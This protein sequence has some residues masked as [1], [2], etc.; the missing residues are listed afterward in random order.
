MPLPLSKNTYFSSDLHFGHDNIIK[1]CNRPFANST[2]MDDFLFKQFADLPN[3]AQLI[4]NGD[5][6]LRGSSFAKNC[7]DKIG[8]MWKHLSVL[9]VRG[10]HDVHIKTSFHHVGVVPYETVVTGANDVVG[11]N[12]HPIEHALDCNVAFCGHVHDKWTTHLT[13]HGFYNINVGWDIW[14]KPVTFVEIC[15]KILNFPECPDGPGFDVAPP[16][17]IRDLLE[18]AAA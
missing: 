8:D 13:Q 12:H 11:L 15:N 3:G 2:E 1:Y 4:L 7:K 14:K 6:A 17:P 5:I 9:I 18:K 10:N 16:K